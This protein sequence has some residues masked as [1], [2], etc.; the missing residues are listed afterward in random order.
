M[1]NFSEK[2]SFIWAVTDLLRGDWRF[3]YKRDIRTNSGRTIK[4]QKR[5]RASCLER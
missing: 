1:S 3:P 2:V 4:C 5:V